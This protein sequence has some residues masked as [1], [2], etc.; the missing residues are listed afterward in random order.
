MCWWRGIARAPS[1]CCSASETLFASS[2]TQWLFFAV[3]LRLFFLCL[4]YRSN[5]CAAVRLRFF[6]MWFFS[7]KR[8]ALL[9]FF[10][11]KIR[12]IFLCDICASG[13]RVDTFFCETCKVMFFT[14]FVN[15][16]RWSEVSCVSD[17]LLKSFR[18]SD[19]F[20]VKCF[21]WSRLFF[22]CLAKW[23]FFREL[24]KLMFQIV[25]L[26]RKPCEV[27]QMVLGFS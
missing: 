16:F 22:M 9:W 8:I 7:K 14:R 6:F 20:L 1:R 18:W 25:Y 24:Y 5:L 10:R 23:Y 13:A 3:R 17:G 4:C 2:E 12:C 15:C 21:R 26:F 11:S 27:F 19:V